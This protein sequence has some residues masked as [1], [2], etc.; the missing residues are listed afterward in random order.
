MPAP[1]S[2]SE[3]EASATP[4]A[5]RFGRH[6]WPYLIG[7][8]AFL[9]LLYLIPHALT[10]NLQMSP[11]ARLGLETQIRD[12]WAKMLWAA[13]SLMGAA[14]VWRYLQ[15]IALVVENSSKT[16][17]AAERTAFF[18]AQAGETERYARAMSLLGD[19]KIE[20][21]LGGIYALERL[22]RESARDHGPIMEVL[23]AYTREHAAWR[24]GQ[25]VAVRPGADLQA[26]LTVIGR[27][28][29]A[30]DPSEGHIDL[31]GTMLSRA[32]LPWAHLERAFL[33]EANLDGAMLQN[34]NLRGAW[35]WK[36]SLIDAVLDGA[37]LEG[38]DLTGVAGL[39]TA[40]LQGAHFDK[41]TKLPEHLRGELD[42][43]KKPRPPTVAKPED[44]DLKLPTMRQ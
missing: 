38:A 28:H 37:H 36:A 22:A 27:R 25:A 39:T 43:P 17:A 20:V 41:T 44:E 1:E 14:L 10:A 6:W 19:E 30:F 26:I 42:G 12:T 32:Y 2:P 8:W 34:A 13:L 9:I 16:L 11:A 5:G 33:Y 23:A 21:R 29:A 3:P 7:G 15:N 24:D 4:R 31:H 35:L 40:Q 18:A